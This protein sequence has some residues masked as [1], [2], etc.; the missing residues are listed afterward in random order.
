MITQMVTTVFKASKELVGFV[1]V[2]YDIRKDMA[3]GGSH[4]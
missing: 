3:L 2:L 1:G 4:D